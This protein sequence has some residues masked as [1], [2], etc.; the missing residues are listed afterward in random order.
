M[1]N[2]MNFIFAQEIDNTIYKI[3]WRESKRIF[4]ENNWRK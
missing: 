4:D 2:L 3:D 1:D